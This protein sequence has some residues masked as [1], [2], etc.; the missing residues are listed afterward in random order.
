MN[1]YID[2]AIICMVFVCMF[3]FFVAYLPLFIGWY[4]A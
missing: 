4:Y 2:N 3:L 1:K